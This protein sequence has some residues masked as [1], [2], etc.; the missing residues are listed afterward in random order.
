MEIRKTENDSTFSTQHILFLLLLLLDIF[1]HVKHKKR[2]QLCGVFAFGMELFFGN[3]PNRDSRFSIVRFE[4]SV[5]KTREYNCF[6]FDL[7]F[8]F[9]V[10][11]HQPNFTRRSSTS[12]SVSDHRLTRIS[13]TAVQ[14]IVLAKNFVKIKTHNFDCHM[15]QKFSV[16][17]VRKSDKNREKKNVCNR[18]I[19]FFKC[20]V[21]IKK[22]ENVR[23]TSSCIF[24]GP[25][26]TF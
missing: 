25:F 2:C 16:Q 5:S 13:H 15:N 18:K 6:A 3:A 21:Y 23:L 20:F 14:W 4:S 19:T 9:F 12:H 17:S 24:L 26:Q 1:S 10:P 8:K 11:N 7:F 22:T